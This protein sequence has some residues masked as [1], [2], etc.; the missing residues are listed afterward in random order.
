MGGG[1]YGNPAERDREAIELD[2]A[3]GLMTR[4]FAD[5]HYAQNQGAPE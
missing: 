3:E 4:A 5:E 1:G 2:I